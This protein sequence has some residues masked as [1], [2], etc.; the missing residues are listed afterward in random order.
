MTDNATRFHDF[1]IDLP[2]SD[3]DHLFIDARGFTVAIILTDEGI[4]VDLYPLAV[5]DEPVASTWA[6][7]NDLPPTIG[8][9]P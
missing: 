8:E 9:Q 1:H 5:A 7:F 4:V 2:C 6:C 3:E